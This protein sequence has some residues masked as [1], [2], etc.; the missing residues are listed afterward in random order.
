MGARFD[1]TTPEYRLR[2]R[3][4]A[5]RIEPAEWTGR[6]VARAVAEALRTA[7]ETSA[8]GP[9]APTGAELRDPESAAALRPGGATRPVVVGAIPFD[10][11]APAVLYIPEEVDWEAGTSTAGAHGTS[12]TEPL[13]IHGE[14]SPG[15]RAAVAD[16]VS[17]IRRGE[18]EK[19]VLARTLTAEAEAP[20]DADALSARLIARN[21]TAFTYRLDLPADAGVLLG[22]SPELVLASEAGRVRSHPLAGSAPRSKDADRALAADLLASAKDLAEHRHV[23]R[24]VAAAFRLFADDVDAP[25]IPSLVETPVIWHLGTEITGR[26]RPEQSPIE[27]LYALHPTPAV[28]G[29][30]SDL[31]RS[32]IAELEYFDR[33]LY[34][35]LVGWMDADGTGE[36]ALT[37]RG[38]IV[39]GT[40]A[41]LYAGAG[42]VAESDPDAEHTETA[43][44]FRTFAGVLGTPRA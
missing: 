4:V 3:G 15:Y 25:E 1:L 34:S 42:I 31:A 6:A 28:C 10:P 35:G 22:A 11:S 14:D 17:R 30:P 33:G 16:A 26:L 7:Q 5:R 41:T 29:W 37:L 21:P 32:T 20:F 27:L 19:V 44:K 40:R 13:R 18:L 39:H 8:P 23:T 38:G 12:P 43:T 9:T 2:T 36:W 24:A